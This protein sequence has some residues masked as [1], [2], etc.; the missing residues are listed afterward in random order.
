VPVDPRHLDAAV[1]AGREVAAERAGRREQ[2][3]RQA[4]EDVRAV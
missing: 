3:Q 4:D 1:L 2:Q